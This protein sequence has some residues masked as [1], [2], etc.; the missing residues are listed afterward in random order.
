MHR[1]IMF[2]QLKTKNSK[3]KT[4]FII[5]HKNRNSL[6]NRRANLRLATKTQNNWNCDRWKNKRRSKYIGISYRPKKKK[7]QAGIYIE[8]K[9]HSLG[10]YDNEVSA[11]KAYDIAAKKHRAEFA[12][13]NFK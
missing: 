4:D 7:Y 11:A 8:N 12:V 10:Y 1:L 3:L 2:K 9:Y 5:D 13:L 6:D